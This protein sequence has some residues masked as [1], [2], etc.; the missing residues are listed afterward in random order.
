LAHRGKTQYVLVA[1]DQLFFRSG[2]RTLLSA[3][4]DMQVV[5]EA[6]SLAEAISRQQQTEPDVI[7]ISAKLVLHASAAE[8]ELVRDWNDRRAVVLVTDPGV[9]IEE[10]ARQ[11]GSPVSVRRSTAA[12]QIVATIRQAAWKE[13]Q[14]ESGLTRT[15][16][17]LKA[18][19]KAHSPKGPVLTSREQEVVRLLAEGRT[20]RETAAELSLSAKTIDAHKLNVMRKL[21]IH[22]REKLIQ[23]AI[24]QRIITPLAV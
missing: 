11:V 15:A 17:G 20:V 10:L 13:E 22:N 21:D 9:S 5:A 8:Q 16:A 19:A 6:S 1:D 23:Y 14:D 24:D 7:V 12:A 18:L 3:E 2:V 4:T